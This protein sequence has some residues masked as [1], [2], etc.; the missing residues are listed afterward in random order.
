LSTAEKVF[1]KHGLRVFDVDKITTH[2]GSLRI[3]ACHDDDLRNHVTERLVLLRSQEKDGG[4]DGLARYLSFDQNVK[5]LK[6]KLLAFL[7][8]AKR[9]GKSIVGYGAAAKANT[10]LNYCGVRSDFID[11]VV[12]RSPHKQGSFLPGT[13]IPICHPDRVTETKPDYLMILPWNLKEEIGQQMK[14]IRDW[15]GKFLIC[16][17]DVKVF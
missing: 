13:H 6:Y 7:I 1:S 8:K 11:Y 9:E 17:P 16:I 10:L 5:A 14:H 15:G 2:G 12:D 3:Y 4:F